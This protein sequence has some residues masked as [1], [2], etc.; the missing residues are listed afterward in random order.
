MWHMRDFLRIADAKEESNPSLKEWVR[1]V[2][3]ISYDVQ[4][5]LD[6]YMLRFTHRSTN[7]FSGS[8]KKSYASM[9][10][11]KARH[12]I[13]SEIQAIKSRLEDAT[14]SQQR[15]REMYVVMDQGSSS[16]NAKNEWYD[17]R[18]DALFLEESD[19]VGIE[20]PKEK[21][22]S[23]FGRWIMGLN[24][25]VWIV[26]SDYTDVKNLLADLIKKLVWET[27]ESP[28]QELE[29]MSADEMREFIYDETHHVYNLEPLPWEKSKVLFYKKAFP[30]NPCPPYLKEFAENILSKCEG[31]PLAIVV[32]GGL[33][34]TKNNRADEWEQ[35]NRSISNELEGGNLHKLS[36]IISLSYYDLPYYLKY[37]FLYLSIFPEGSLL[38]KEKVIRLWTAEGFVQVKHDKTMEEV[39]EDY[40]NELLSRSLIQV[41]DNAVDGRPRMFQIHD[42]LREYISSKSREQNIVAIY[43]E[44]EIQW[45]NKIRRLA[46]QKWT[47]V[48]SLE[49]ES[50]KY[51]RSLLLLHIGVVESIP[52][53]ELISRCRV[54]KVL[55][56]GGAPLETIPNEVFISYN[57]KYLSLRNTM[58]KL[59]PKSI[60]YL[61]NLETLDLKNSKVTELPIEILKLRRL[62]HLLVY[63]YKGY[64]DVTFDNIQSARAPC[65][66]GDYLSSLQKL[67]WIDANEVNG[68]K[69]VREIGKLTQLR[70][71]GIA[72]LRKA[73]GM[74][75]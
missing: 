61:K 55:D 9:K 40:L 62:R 15:Y 67:S 14:K 52:I 33:L 74:E 63:R 1:Q 39:A 34:A 29:D 25:H 19:V 47:T 57:L 66:I 27:K 4:D 58:V 59:I 23:G 28:P 18:S 16:T 30:R 31:L 3:E 32:I 36:K 26:A 42:L 41:A 8:I 65:H 22:L 43:G 69:M 53:K 13:A 2:R 35:F 56:L 17:G 6:K 21:F 5:V 51:L 49:T 24:R 68:I 45:P 60:K 44:G 75:L 46:I 37:C 72:K 12:K 10:N 54:L 11:V 70:R 50:F 7:R 64:L 20:K 38:E 73:D 71:L 48:F